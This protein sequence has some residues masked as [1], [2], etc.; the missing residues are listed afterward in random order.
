MPA[1]RG[2]L[3]AEAAPLRREISVER[4][5]RAERETVFRGWIEPARLMRWWGPE[6]FTS[7]LFEVDAREGGAWRVEMR[8]P[9]GTVYPTAGVFGE[10]VAGEKLVFLSAALNDDGHP[11]FEMENIATFEAD[12][13][14]TIVRFVARLT[15]WWPEAPP[16]LDAMQEGWEQS[17]DR[18]DAELRRR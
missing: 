3:C 15:W 8:G 9:D 12:R 11:L 18:L 6:G 1:V 7:P 2:S 4:A 13:S 16:N 17:L 10:I 14:G 5:I